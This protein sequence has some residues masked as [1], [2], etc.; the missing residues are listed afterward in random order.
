MPA[1]SAPGATLF[2]ASAVCLVTR[3]ELLDGS[4]VTSG[5]ALF[6]IASSG[7]H[8]NGYSLVRKILGDTRRD[9][10][11]ARQ[12][13]TPTKLY[14]AAAQVMRQAVGPDLHGLCHITGSSFLNIPRL[15]EKHHYDVD[16]TKGYRELPVFTTLRERGKLSW[17]DCFTTFNMGVGMVAAV[18]RR[19]VEDPARLRKLTAALKRTGYRAFPLGRVG[20]KVGRGETSRV[21]IEGDGF[22]LQLAY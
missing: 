21:A 6:G 12:C 8:S 5:D 11:L 14:V 15:S 1:L 13:L 20:V 22:H 2:P 7:I 4:K 19:I 18:H 10:A 9:H 16:L 3:N 17:R